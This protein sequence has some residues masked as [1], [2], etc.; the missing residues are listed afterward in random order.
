[1]T[2]IPHP[3]QQLSKDETCLARDIIKQCHPHEVIEFRVISLQEPPKAE[4]LVF[5][6][7]EHREAVSSTSPRPTRLAKCLYDTIGS[8]K[9]PRY[10]ES[11]V[12]LGQQSR[13]QHDIIPQDISPSLTV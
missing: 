7:I 12:D 9:V 8:D 6:D 4:L 13:I 2:I 10:N 5:L 3:F 11:V 1:M